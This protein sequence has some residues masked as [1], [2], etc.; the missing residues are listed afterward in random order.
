MASTMPVNILTQ[1]NTE[2]VGCIIDS[3]MYKGRKNES[4]GSESRN[5]ISAAEEVCS[6]VIDINPLSFAMFTQSLV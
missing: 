4:I 6:E 3:T 2:V 5:P 1:V